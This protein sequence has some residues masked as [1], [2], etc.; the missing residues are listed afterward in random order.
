[1]KRDSELY[2]FRRHL[3][4]CKYFG[5]GGRAVRLDKCKCPFHVDGKHRDER[6][7]KALKTTSHQ[8]ADNR[9]RELIRKL[10]ARLD[11][12]QH[13][14]NAGGLPPN[15]PVRARPMISEAIDLF[16]ATHGEIDQDGKFH[17]DSE[18]NTYRKY[19]SSL[20]FL[21]AYCDER[22]I[23]TLSDDMA[24][25]LQ[26]YRR[27]RCIGGVAWRTERQLLI[28][29]F[30]FCI[31]RK[32]IT[33]NPAREL[34]AP[35]NLKPNEV[36]PYTIQEECLILAAC[37]QFGGGK[38]N[39]SGAA[40][41]QLRVRAMVMLL[42]HTALRISDVAAL[43]KDAV[44]WD[45]E[46][47]TWRIRVRTQKTG[48]PVH[49]PIPETLKL[50]LDALPPPRGAAQDC[51]CYFWNGITSR[52]AVVGIAERTLAAVFKKSGVKNAHAHRTAIRSPRGCW[53]RA[54]RSS[55]WP[56]SWATARK[57]SGSTTASGPRAGR[58]TS[59]GS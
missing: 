9:L 41:E 59:T 45:L 15:V 34:S 6:V 57:W 1:M 36:V 23:V 12:Q 56:T 25:A 22:R 8:L 26:G 18:Y 48:E 44:S 35:R 11:A 19:R 32:W 17:G 38:Y 4:G 47:A 30:G 43:R 58:T 28:T 40:Y 27:T 29:F 39:R 55:R 46:N 16:L 5:R 7:R 24:D 54:P 53:S 20:R 49:L 33:T 37:D 50:A 31:K 42:R 10:D 14:A 2:P 51:P 3:R 13:V 52:R 21:S